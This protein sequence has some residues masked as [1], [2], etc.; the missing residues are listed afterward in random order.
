MQ[1]DSFTPE[2]QRAAQSDEGERSSEPTPDSQS[3]TQPDVVPSQ[4]ELDAQLARSRESQQALTDELKALYRRLHIELDAA[5]RSALIVEL[6]NDPRSE[7][8]LLGF[9]LADRDLSASKTLGDDVGQAVRGLLSDPNDLIRAK[10]A[11]LIT[12]LVPPDGMIVLTHALI[13]ENSPV[14]ADP[15]LMG[16]AR[17]PNP[18]A[19]PTVRAWAMRDDAPVSALFSAAWAFERESLWTPET[20]YPVLLKKL[21]NS[22]S[23]QMREDGMKLLAKLGSSEDLRQLVDLMLSNDQ[24]VVRWAASSLVETPRAVEVLI[25]SAAENEVLY[26]AAA[27][28]LI[29]HRAT[30]E[31]MRRLAELPQ[32]D[33][34]VRRSSLERMGQQIDREQLGEAV[35]LSRLDQDIAISILSR[36]L[37]SEA[38]QSTRIAK[39]VLQLGELQLDAGR[40]NRVIE[41]VIALEGATL[42]PADQLRLQSMQTQS[43]ILLSRFDDAAAAQLDFDVW[44]NALKRAVD[45][46]QRTRIANELLQR[47]VDELSPDQI[48]FLQQQAGRVPSEEATR[49]NEASEDEPADG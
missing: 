1:R 30:P 5:G 8:K 17:W 41:A 37:T 34:A 38:T 26:Q 43:L 9:E 6:F 11:R 14:A 39:G 45:E 10:S 3:S 40:P 21:R 28:A 2:P 15:M 20:D 24:S 16:I 22:T 47:F 12:R 36:L 46:T 27:E 48:E 42:D 25:Q 29:K 35:R 13:A 4:P 18:D 49:A 23:V 31:G 19:V 7:F 44:N 33:S 32:T